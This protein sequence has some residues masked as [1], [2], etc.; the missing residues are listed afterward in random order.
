MIDLITKGLPDTVTIGGEPF[1]IETDFRPWMRFCDEFEMW[2]Q[3]QSLNVSYLFADEIPHISTAEDMQAIIGFAYPPATVP[4]SGGGDGSRV[5][6]YRIDAD[7]IYS[8][9]LQQYGI[10]LTETGMHWHKFR[11]LLNG[12]SSATKLH[13][14]IGYRCYNG[15][16][17]EYK[18][19][20]EMWALPVKLSAADVQTVQDFEAYFE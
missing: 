13:E 8:A 14:I 18:R 1:L 15:D 3:K 6:D 2:D 19:L 11:A 4:K 9:F 17:K 10:D 20:R 5:L 12:L 16:D 7:Y